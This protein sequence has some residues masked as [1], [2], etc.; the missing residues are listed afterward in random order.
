MRK[1]SDLIQVFAPS[2]LI[3]HVHLLGL[4]WHFLYIVCQQHCF[5]KTSTISFLAIVTFP[6]LHYFIGFQLFLLHQYLNGKMS[7]KAPVHYRICNYSNSW[8]QK[9]VISNYIAILTMLL[10]YGTGCP[11]APPSLC[12]TSGDTAIFAAQP[13]FRQIFE[14]QHGI[15]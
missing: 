12:F 7:Y 9:Y 6:L 5:Q 14:V 13:I 2:Y 3:S 11:W 4:S 1:I 15:T 8:S 10:P